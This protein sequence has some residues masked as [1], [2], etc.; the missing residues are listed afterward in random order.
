MGGDTDFAGLC[1]RVDEVERVLLEL[2]TGHGRL[3]RQ[4]ADVAAEQHAARE[5]RLGQEQRMAAIEARLIEDGHRLDRLAD[6]MLS[7]VDAQGS[8]VQR[9]DGIGE[10][11]TAATVITEDIA[12]A[13]KWIE[14]LRKVLVWVGSIALAV[15]SIWAGVKLAITGH[16]PPPPPPPGAGG[17]F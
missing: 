15:G 2:T 8:I 1:G 6:S 7:M 11:I 12:I 5:H 13:I 4:V 17:P 9:L 14:R 3:T 10:Q 16:A